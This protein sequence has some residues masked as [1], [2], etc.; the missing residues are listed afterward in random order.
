MFRFGDLC[1]LCSQNDAVI[2]RAG[3]QE[4][5]S[6]YVFDSDRQGLDL[7]WNKRLIYSYERGYRPNRLL[8]DAEFRS[9]PSAWLS[10]ARISVSPTHGR[11]RGRGGQS[12]VGRSAPSVYDALRLWQPKASSGALSPPGQRL[13]RDSRG[14][15]H[16]HLIPHLRPRRRPSTARSVPLP[17]SRLTSTSA[18]RSTRPKSPTGPMSGLPDPGETRPYHN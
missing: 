18:M 14:D 17:V 2:V 5:G 15:N 8:R 1:L 13:A 12:R 7:E 6:A 10:C 11:P 16:H 4:A 3:M 9:R